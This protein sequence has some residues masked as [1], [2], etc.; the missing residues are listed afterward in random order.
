MLLLYFLPCWL[1]SL[2][3]VKDEGLSDEAH[4]AQEIS[5]LLKEKEKL[6]EVTCFCLEQA[7]HIKWFRKA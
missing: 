6:L 1:C 4:K 7:T 5:V 2:T 3:F